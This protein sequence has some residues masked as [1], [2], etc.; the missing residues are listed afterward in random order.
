MGAGTVSV[1]S[2]S[3]VLAYQP[4]V[5]LAD[6]TWLNG[7]FT[8]SSIGDGHA[9]CAPGPSSAALPSPTGLPKRKTTARCCGST[10]KKPE[11]KNTTT[12]A[13]MM[14]FTIQKLL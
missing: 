5:E 6:C 7:T 13:A 11:M 12:R 14:N 1:A 3:G 9:Q 10:M 8:T 4:R 2:C